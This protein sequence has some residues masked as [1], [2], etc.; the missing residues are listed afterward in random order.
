MRRYA[1]RTKRSA[2]ARATDLGNNANGFSKCLRGV[3]VEVPGTPN[4]P[5]SQ[6]ILYQFCTTT[7]I[8]AIFLPLTT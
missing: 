8:S 3:A 5:S 7:R 2:T 6:R 1:V 4:R